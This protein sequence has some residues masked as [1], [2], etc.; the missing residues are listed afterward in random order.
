MVQFTINGR[1]RFAAG[2]EDVAGN[3]DGIAQTLLADGVALAVDLE[4]INAARAMASVV[5]EF[6]QH[7]VFVIAQVPDTGETVRGEIEVRHGGGGG[8]GGG[9][10]GRTRYAGQ[11]QD[12]IAVWSTVTRRRA[13]VQLVPRALEW[14]Q[15]GGSDRA[16]ARRSE[17]LRGEQ[18]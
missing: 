17:S 3:V 1:V 6:R 2:A 15:L 4:W 9:G 8:G 10:C 12:G 11:L 18:L 7:K 5:L 14:R 13:V 16:I